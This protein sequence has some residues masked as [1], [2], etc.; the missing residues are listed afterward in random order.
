MATNDAARRNKIVEYDFKLK[1]FG[2]V[3]GLPDLANQMMVTIVEEVL[4]LRLEVDKLRA[5][6]A[7]ADL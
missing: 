6:L 7:E 5:R 3:I 4:Y 2:G 1:E